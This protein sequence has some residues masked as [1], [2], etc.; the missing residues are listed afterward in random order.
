MEVGIVIR[1]EK[2]KIAK[3]AKLRVAGCALFYLKEYGKK[4]D[5]YKWLDE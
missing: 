1:I 2:R 4:Y 5:R 3:V